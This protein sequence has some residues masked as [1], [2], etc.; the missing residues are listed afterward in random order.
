MANEQESDEKQQKALAALDVIDKILKKVKL[1]LVEKIEYAQAVKTIR[2]FVQEAKAAPIVV[3][4]EEQPIQADVDAPRNPELLSLGER[5]TT[6]ELSNS[7]SHALVQW[8]QVREAISSA[9]RA[10]DKRVTNMSVPARPN[11]KMKNTFDQRNGTLLLVASTSSDAYAL[12]KDDNGLLT[13]TSARY[14]KSEN[15]V[16]GRK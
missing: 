7:L 6:E 8:S 16:S 15:S 9:I 14:W 1:E 13:L 3:E 5:K 4:K 10:P 2:S 11:E 12:T